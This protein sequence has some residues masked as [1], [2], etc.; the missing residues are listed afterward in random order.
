ME[1]AGS[2]LVVVLHYID[3]DHPSN[4]PFTFLGLHLHS[5]VLLFLRRSRKRL[6]LTGTN[7]LST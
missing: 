2:L 3:M 6:F 4:T 5:K 7:F 1:F